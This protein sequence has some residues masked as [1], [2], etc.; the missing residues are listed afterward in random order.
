MVEEPTATLV[1]KLLKKARSK[2]GANIMSVSTPGPPYRPAL[3]SK[4]RRVRLPAPTLSLV[5]QVAAPLPFAEVFGSSPGSTSKEKVE[6]I[7]RQEVH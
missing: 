1:R 6:I 4:P 2:K 7:A 3:P 5:E